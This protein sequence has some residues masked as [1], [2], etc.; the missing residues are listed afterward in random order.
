MI[1]ISNKVNTDF[2]NKVPRLP[3]SKTPDLTKIPET[4]KLPSTSRRVKSKRVRVPMSRSG[5]RS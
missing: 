4:E 2:S 3:I 5:N 1:D